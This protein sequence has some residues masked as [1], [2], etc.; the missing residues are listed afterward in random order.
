MQR[1][2]AKVYKGVTPLAAKDVAEAILWAVKQPDHV[3]YSAPWC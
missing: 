1:E 3:N 2:R